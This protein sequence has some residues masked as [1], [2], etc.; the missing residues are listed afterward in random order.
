MYI[1]YHRKLIDNTKQG[2]VIYVHGST[3]ERGRNGMN[4]YDKLN[5]PTLVITDKRTKEAHQIKKCHSTAFLFTH[6]T[7]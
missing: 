5:I 6:F 1:V 7:G 4:L 2:V 3:S